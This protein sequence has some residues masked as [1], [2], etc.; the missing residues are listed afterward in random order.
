MKKNLLNEMTWKEA[1]ILFKKTDVAIINCGAI[2]PHGSAC[3]LGTDNIGAYEVS[4]KISKKCLEQGIDV[5]ILPNIPFGYN[6]YHGDFEGNISIDKPTLISYYWNVVK[7]LHKWGI[8]KIIWNSTHGGNEPCIEDVSSRA[9]REFG[10]IAVRFAWD[11]TGMTLTQDGLINTPIKEGDEGLILEMSLV[12][13]VRPEIIDFSDAAFK[14]Y[15]KPFGDEFQ[16]VDPHH[17][18]FGKSTLYTYL[19]TRDATS[20]GGY[21]GPEQRN[22]SK[23]SAES[24]KIIINGVVDY[25]VDFIKAFTE[26]KL[27]NRINSDLGT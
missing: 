20:T 8:R 6:Y 11:S 19:T 21:G 17:I 7:W 9:R 24:G 3:P 1:K 23:A 18:L 15:E 16:I 26:L 25:I 2:H 14:E 12:A 4:K 13:A 22:Y 5:V 10:M 27:K